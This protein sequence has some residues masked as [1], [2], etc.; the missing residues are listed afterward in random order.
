MPGAQRTGSRRW[1]IACRWRQHGVVAA[2][3]RNR[4]QIEAEPEVVAAVL[5]EAEHYPRWVVGAESFRGGDESFPEAGSRFHHSVSLGPWSL[6]DHTEVLESELPARIVLKAKARP[7][8]T[9]RV[10]LSLAASAGG[11]EVTMEETPGDRLSALFTGN[12]VAD[13]ALRLRNAEALTRLRRIVEAAPPPV[14][15]RTDVAGR[16]VLI[17]GG[18][19]GIG[20]ASA[21]RLALE[22][23]RV[24]LLARGE[25]G[26]AAA[27]RRLETAGASG[28]RTVAADVT[29]REALAAAVAEA[30][31]GMGGLDL[32]ICSAVGLSYGR[33]TETS[34][35]DF[36]ATI[37]TTFGGMVNAI[38]S[39][40]PQLE[41]SGGA[42]VVV[43]SIAG[44][45]PLPTLSAYSAAKHATVG[46]V[47]SLRI[48]LAEAGS[49]VAVS[50]VH[51]GPV[52]TPLWG[53]LQS[54]NGLLPP[55]PPDLY[56]AEAVADVVA[57]V[58][59][60]PR[61][62][63]IVGGVATLEVAA[64]ATLRRPTERALKAL[65][66][67]ALSAGDR[68]AGEGAL[69]AA[70]GTGRIEGGFGS[71]SSLAVR[72]LAALERARRAVGAA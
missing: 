45:M 41:R 66:R 30:A 46:F 54:A 2:V 12:P 10:E 26:L 37:G 38:R 21:E 6:D 42:I 36:E 59:R 61:P 32:L 56:S 44:R 63:T 58:V 11:T 33:F 35:E 22:G 39:A 14:P 24:T 51:P 49:S 17:T 65:A 48:E 52:D 29:D 53:N 5:S 1:L 62:E 55:V 40:L 57:A 43:G 9:A 16:R 7:L 68:R 50:L 72:G 4:I 18:S 64:Y 60:R 13:V 69:R 31:A 25:M 34:A 15:P 28:V 27:K 70:S 47:E 23:A 8:G 20:L 19:S 3:A 67:L 71:R